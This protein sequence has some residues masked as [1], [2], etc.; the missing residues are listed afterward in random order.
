MSLNKARIINL[1]GTTPNVECMFNPKEYTFAKS[2]S[3]GKGDESGPQ[4]NAGE[5]TFSGGEGATLVSK[6]NCSSLTPTIKP[7]A[8]AAYK[9]CA[10]T[11]TVCGC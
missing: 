6:N 1:D 8:A 7:K 3:W 5:I 11:P 9:T 2:N 4:K 10:I